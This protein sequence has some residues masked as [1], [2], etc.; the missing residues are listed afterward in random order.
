[1]RLSDNELKKKLRS[2]ALEVYPESALQN[3]I[4]ASEEAFY[5][6][7]ANSPLSGFEFL[8]QQGRYLRRR[9]W[10]MQAVLL[11]ALWW[12]LSLGGSGYYLKRLM[13]TAASLFGVLLLPELWKNQSSNAMEIEC[14]SYYSLRQVY[15]ARLFWFAMIDLILL[16]SFAAGVVGAGEIL[17][18]DM[19][20]QF[21]LP[22]VVTCCICF[23][24]LYSRR[25]T[26]ETFSIFLCLAWS[27]IWTQIVLSE[28]VYQSLSL[29]V[30]NGML[31]AAAFYLGYCICRGQKRCR[32]IWEVK[33]LWN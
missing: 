3:T 33:S 20:V 29:P 2:R 8:Y 24:C 28:R 15:A 9:W 4:Y 13:G 19:A 23:H 10:V 7:E 25:I 27:G 14:A 5:E 11:L 22:Y 16:G 17:I 12:L 21:F 26:S 18:Q 1:M 32:E 31:A 6:K 30:W